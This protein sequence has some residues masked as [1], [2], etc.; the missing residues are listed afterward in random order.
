MEN[1]KQMES[2]EL[3]VEQLAT[4]AGGVAV[5]EP[6]PGQYPTDDIY[7]NLSAEVTKK[8]ENIKLPNWQ[9]KYKYSHTYSSE[10]SEG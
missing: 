10:S 4:I 6:Y 8:L 3:S 2:Q 1:E 5:G 9:E 7:K